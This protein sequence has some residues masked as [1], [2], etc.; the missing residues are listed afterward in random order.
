MARADV[1]LGRGECRGAMT[2]RNVC[3][4]VMLG[5]GIGI[6]GGDQAAMVPVVGVSFRSALQHEGRKA[7]GL[8]SI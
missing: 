2:T 4:G 7:A 8:T 1:S 5:V 3:L 6:R